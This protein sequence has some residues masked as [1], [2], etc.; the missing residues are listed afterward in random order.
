MSQLVCIGHLNVEDTKYPDRPLVRKAAGGAALYS[1][2]AARMWGIEVSIISRI[3]EDYPVQYL[4]ALRNGGIR[5]D[6]IVQIPGQTMAGYTSYDRLGNRKYSMYTPVDRRLEL[7]PIPQDWN[8]TIIQVDGVHIA[9][10]PP[11]IQSQWLEYLRP[12]S[13]FISLDTDI[14]FVQNERD[15]LINLLEKVDAFFPNWQEAQAFAPGLSIDEIAANLLTLGPKIVVIKCGSNG[16]RVYNK[17]AQKPIIVSAAI[18][19]VV[20]VTGAGDSYAG[21][22]IAGYLLNRNIDQAAL[23]GV[24]SAAVA[25]EDYGGVH[26]LNRKNEEFIARLNQL[27]RERLQ[28]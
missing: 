13:G 23:M 12:N 4:R 28:L 20:D 8:A 6:S 21:G 9:T 7:T 14:S 1:A 22:F 18:S 3:G 25:I 15:N 27:T 16:A 24:V 5:I 10:M 2:V 26:T 11:N 17:N 19:Q